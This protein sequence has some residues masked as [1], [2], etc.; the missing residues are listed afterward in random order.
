MTKETTIAR[1]EVLAAEMLIENNGSQP[2]LQFEDLALWLDKY[3]PWT[4]NALERALLINDLRLALMGRPITCGLAS[5]TTEADR[6]AQETYSATPEVR[7]CKIATRCG[8]D[9]DRLSD[10]AR[11]VVLMENAAAI[12]RHW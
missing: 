8:L 2:S 12:R 1:P 3:I 11:W 9:W 7:A 4:I 6:L 5:I 10:A